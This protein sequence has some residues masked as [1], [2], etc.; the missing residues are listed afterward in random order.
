MSKTRNLII[1][2]VASTVQKKYFKEKFTWF[3]QEMKI[4][5]VNVM[6]V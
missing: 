6:C 5:K 2:D 1:E 4:L 3:L